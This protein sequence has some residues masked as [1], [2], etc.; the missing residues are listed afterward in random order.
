MQQQFPNSVV[1]GDPTVYQARNEQD[2]SKNLKDEITGYSL[3]MKLIEHLFYGGPT[4][5]EFEK[6]KEFLE[7][8]RSYYT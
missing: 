8:Y 6:C 4:S 1:F 5:S 2:L 7:L 3:T